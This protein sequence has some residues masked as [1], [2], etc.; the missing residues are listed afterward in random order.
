MSIRTIARASLAAAALLPLL[1]EALSA[2]TAIGDAIEA[3]AATITPETVHAH[4]SFLAS[5]DLLGRD[6]PS[7]G[8]EEA[9]AYLIRQHEASGLQ[10]A[11]EG[12]T[13]IQ[14]FPLF[15]ATVP[16]VL[17]MIPGEDPSL[18]DEYI[19]LS[20]HFDHVG[21][22]QP[23]AGD[24]IYN[25]ADDNGSGTAALVEVARVLAALPEGE[26]AR[27]TILIAHV[28]AE[29]KGLLGSR[30]WVD[31]PTVPIE[32]V[33]ANVNVDMIG[34]SM[35][36][37]T[38]VVLGR[39]YSSLGPLFDDVNAGLPELNLTTAPDLWPQEQL[40]FR[41]DQLNFMRRE[42]PAV[43]LFTGLHECYHSPCDDID[44]VDT[45]KVSRIA[46]LIAHTVYQMAN[47]EAR[48]QWDPAGLQEVRRMLS[49]GG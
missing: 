33:I 2:Q 15:E 7:P 9:A 45:E 47:A 32:N 38:L 6:T 3:S 12:G 22:G 16:N 35:H 28:S 10:P 44:F 46:R 31:N 20:A 11:G 19:V 30:W 5:D 40:F 36:P 39:E 29:E 24:S 14:R 8:L 13:F 18:R 37:D 27:R 42:I 25:G 23:I 26:R 34:G 49:G 17:A 43:F 1:G 21:V 48:P 41:S 4:I